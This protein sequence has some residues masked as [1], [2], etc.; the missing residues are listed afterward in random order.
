MPQPLILVLMPFADDFDDVYHVGIKEVCEKVGARCERLDEQVH[1]DNILQRIY[2]QIAGADLIVADT[3]GRNPNVYYEIGYA[4]ALGKRVILL[5]RAA[6]DIPFDFKHFPHIVYEGRLR[7]LRPQLE[8]HLLQQLAEPGDSPLEILRSLEGYWVQEV[9]GSQRPVSV[10]WIRPDAGGQH[11]F[12]GE[13]FHPDGRLFATFA[14]EHLFYDA[15]ERKLWYIY[16]SCEA[17][18]PGAHVWGFGALGVERRRDE[19]GR[20]RHVLAGGFY[21]SLVPDAVPR[22]VAYVRGDA[23]CARL[24]MDAARLEDPAGRRELARLYAASVAP[25]PP[26]A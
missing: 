24:G 8:R 19:S 14:S 22:T 2:A 7:L 20:E 6:E 5:T 16:R 17:A 21:R 26:G 25:P 23:L 3:T 9:P 11:E 10:G 15:H 4:H 1:G 18:T 12:C 13:N